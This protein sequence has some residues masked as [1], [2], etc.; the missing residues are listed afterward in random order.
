MQRLLESICQQHFTGFEV[1]I[2]DDSKTDV[3]EE[4]VVRFK[5]RLP[6]HYYRNNPPS[7]MG[8][9]WN[10]C[11][12]KA[13]A[14][15]IKTMH[16][17]D[18][19]ADPYAL[20]KFAAAAQSTTAAFI[21]CSAGN[22]MAKNKTRRVDKLTGSRKQMLD[23]SPLSLLYTNIIG[24]PSVTMYRREEAIVF[25]ARFKWVIDIDFYIRYLQQHGNQYYYI[26]E[27]LINITKDDNQVSASCYKNPFVEIPEYLVLLSKFSPGLHLQNK[28]AF[29]CLWELVRKFSLTDPSDLALYGYSGTVPE[30]LEAIISYQKRVPRIILK[31]TPGNTRLM[32]QCFDGLKN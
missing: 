9:N 29:Y 18:W 14:P 26:D 6:V 5:D 25:D 28:Y 20:E 30:K 1:I 16:D 24:H 17:D 23:E 22:V 11:N 8:N 31:Q 10:T 7:G 12:D 4:T 3:V 27:G 13:S 21:F 15:W 2:T 19:F 32:K